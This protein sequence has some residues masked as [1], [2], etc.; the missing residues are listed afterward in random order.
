MACLGTG[1]AVESEGRD[2]VDMELPGQQR[3]LLEMVME[4]AANDSSTRVALLLFSAGPLNISFAVD[5][6]HV[7]AIVQCFFPAQQTGEALVNTLF[8]I[9]RNLFHYESDRYDSDYHATLLVCLVCVCVCV[10][11]WRAVWR[12]YWADFNQTYPNV[13]PN[14]LVVRVCDL[15]H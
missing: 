4:H 3:R 2:R 12:N 14:G 8:E 5:S 13:F 10:C 9:G 6:P 1:L 11:L 15:A 7:H